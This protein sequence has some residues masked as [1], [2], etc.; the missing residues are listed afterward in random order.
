M[1]YAA[2]YDVTRALRLL[3]HSQLAL[4]SATAVVTLHPPGDNLPDASGV[5][6]Y[7][8]R[9]A[10]SPFARNRDWPGDRARPGADRPAMGLQL[11]YLLTPLGAKPEDSSFQLGDDAHTMLGAAMLTLHEHPVLNAVHLPGFDADTA[12]PEYLLNS[13]EQIKV[14]LTPIGVDE[15][16]KI[17]STLN[18]PYRLSVAYEVSLVQLVPEAPAPAGG[19]IV[20]RAEVEVVTADPPRLSALTPARGALARVVGGAIQPNELRVEGYGLLLPGQAPTVRVGGQSVAPRAEP[21]PTDRALTISLP[22]A[23]DAGPEVDVRVALG[24]RAGAPL[25]FTVS[26]WL[27]ELRPLRTALDPARPAELR[28]ELRGSGI[29]APQAVRLDGPGG[30]HSLTGFAAGGDDGRAGV[31]LPADLANGRYEARVVLG[32]GSVSNPRALEVVP[33]LGAEVGVDRVAGA[34]GEVHRLSF[35][36]ARLAG[37]DVRL[38]LD[39]TSYSLGANGEAGQLVVTLGRLLTPGAHRA[40]ARVDGQLSRAVEFFV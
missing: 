31:D 39:G 40:A 23:L 10:E 29:G 22:A 25:V 15:L 16:S 24:G 20:T 28:L 9:V 27:A 30:H 12:L 6:L 4:R 26:P 37:A 13:Y 17:W 36:G 32:D 14:L 18:K 21:A 2:I 3:L 35:S 11:Y 34:T 7:L 19:G 38:E 33:L 1:S 8:Y 5:N